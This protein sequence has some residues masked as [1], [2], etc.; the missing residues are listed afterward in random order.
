MNE[1]VEYISDFVKKFETFEVPPINVSKDAALRA[2][3]K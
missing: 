1:V 3:K 2:L